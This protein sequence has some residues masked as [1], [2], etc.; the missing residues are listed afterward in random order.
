MPGD[1]SLAAFT[2]VLN[3]REVQNIC[4]R[5]KCLLAIVHE[6]EWVNCNLKEMNARRKKNIKNTT[7]YKL[8]NLAHIPVLL[9]KV[10]SL[11]ERYFWLL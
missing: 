10:I 4:C 1:N 2:A 6:S 7:G 11:Q 5:T 9:V 8:N 3:Y